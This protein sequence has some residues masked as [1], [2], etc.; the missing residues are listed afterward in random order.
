MYD[1]TELNSRLSLQSEYVQRV[2]TRIQHHREVMG[3]L[4][5]LRREF[6]LRRQQVT[7]G[8]GWGSK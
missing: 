7:P 6:T 5:S 3:K 4:R 1:A 2:A 8:W